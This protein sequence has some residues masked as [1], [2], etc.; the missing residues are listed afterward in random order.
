MR[1]LRGRPV[2]RLCGPLRLRRP[3]RLCST[4]RRLWGL[5]RLVARLR[6][7]RGHRLR[8]RLLAVDVGPRLG[9]G[10]LLTEPRHFGGLRL[11]A[12]RAYVN[13]LAWPGRSVSID[14]TASCFQAPC[15]ARWVTTG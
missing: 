11:L 8:R 10:L 3:L 15:A 2:R 9:M 6:R 14:P 7:L 1:R 12:G 13:V 5:R 4:V